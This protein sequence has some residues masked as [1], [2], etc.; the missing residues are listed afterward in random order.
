M[1]FR[2]QNQLLHAPVVE[3]GDI[4]FVLRRTSHGVQP[5]ELPEFPPA[6]A[7]HAHYLSVERQLI[8]AAR[9]GV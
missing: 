3:V 5:T 8:H 9:I 4:Q 7:E 6:D 2:M 1:W